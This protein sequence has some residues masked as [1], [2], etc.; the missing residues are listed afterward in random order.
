M[1]RIPEIWFQFMELDLLVK[2][3]PRVFPV[4]VF[5]CCCLFASLFFLKLV[6]TCV[7]K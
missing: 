6:H 7:L 1:T 2:I 5:C 3:R 4:T